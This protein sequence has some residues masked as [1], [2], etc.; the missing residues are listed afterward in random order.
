[1][2]ESGHGL[3]RR[4]QDRQDRHEASAAHENLSA[5]P[6]PIALRTSESTRVIHLHDLLI[7][8]CGSPGQLAFLVARNGQRPEIPR[9]IS[10]VLVVAAEAM[11][12]GDAVSIVPAHHALTTQQAADLLTPSR[13]HL[14]RLLE[15]GARHETGS[16]RR[17]CFEDLMRYRDLCH[18]RRRQAFREFTRKSA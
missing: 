3:K 18:T 5:T 16:H 12:Q 7:E 2:F 13:P 10:S 8:G 17:V 1:M 4:A 9:A 15:R 6:R 14:V 11:A